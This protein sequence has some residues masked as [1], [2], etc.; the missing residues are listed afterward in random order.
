MLNIINK[1]WRRFLISIFES[2]WHCQRSFLIHTLSI[3]RQKVKIS[4]QVFQE[5]K[6]RQ[7]FTD[8]LRKG[9]WYTEGKVKAVKSSVICHSCSFLSV[10]LY[11]LW[12]VYKE[13]AVKNCV[14]ALK[15]RL[16]EGIWKLFS[17]FSEKHLSRWPSQLTTFFKL[18]LNTLWAVFLLIIVNK[19]IF[20]GTC[21][22]FSTDATKIVT[23]RDVNSLSVIYSTKV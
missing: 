21:H 3:I 10:I 4:K 11:C 6:A 5:N 20:T 22:I 18:L 7:I 19:N 8:D 16:K 13:V 15:L 9:R 2:W 12:Y 14:A 23:T 17:I 1:T